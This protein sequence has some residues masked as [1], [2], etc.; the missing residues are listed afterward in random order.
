MGP[1]RETVPISATSRHSSTSRL[2]RMPRAQLCKVRTISFI[3]LLNIKHGYIAGHCAFGIDMDMQNGLNNI[4]MQ[5][6]IALCAIDRERLFIVKLSN[7]MP[8]RYFGPNSSLVL[9][10]MGTFF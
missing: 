7:V 10:W 2:H 1:I 8:F 3:F 5:K 6:T 9:H 4:Y